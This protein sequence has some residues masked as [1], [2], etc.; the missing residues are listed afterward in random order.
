MHVGQASWVASKVGVIHV[1]SIKAGTECG[2]SP[3]RQ[4]AMQQGGYSAARWVQWEL[5]SKAG[6][7]KQGRVQYSKVDTVQQ[8][9]L[10]FR[11]SSL[12]HKQVEPWCEIFQPILHAAVPV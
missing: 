5:C 1:L 9:R 3:V 7:V 2:Y 8:D 11:G 4:G 10:H 12:V 6:A